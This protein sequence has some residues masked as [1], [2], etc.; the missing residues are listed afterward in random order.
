MNY[1][2]QCANMFTLYCAHSVPLML[3]V[4]PA[5]SIH[6]LALKYAV[7]LYMQ[8]PIWCSALV[9]TGSQSNALTPSICSMVT[10][11][12]VVSYIYGCTL[13]MILVMLLTRHILNLPMQFKVRCSMVW[14]PHLWLSCWHPV[15]VYIAMQWSP[16]A[17]IGTSHMHHLTLASV[18]RTFL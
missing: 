14:S 12:M 7:M 1:L 2:L 18:N 11:I 9:C 13:I 10:Y 17:C 4:I 15:F 8:F 3:Y 5:V 6:L 16:N